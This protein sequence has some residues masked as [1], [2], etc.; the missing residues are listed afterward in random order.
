MLKPA[1]DDSECA[2]RK[3][4]EVPHFHRD[5]EEFEATVGQ[6]AEAAEVLD[7]GNVVAQ[8]YGVCRTITV[9]RGVD[10]EGVDPN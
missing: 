2:H 7:D 4:S 5:G 3:R 10:V 6:V 8:Q 9:A 1:G